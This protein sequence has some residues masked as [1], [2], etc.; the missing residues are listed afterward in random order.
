MADSPLLQISTAHLLIAHA[1]YGLV[2][3]FAVS[4]KW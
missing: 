4:R 2:L 1:V 3:G